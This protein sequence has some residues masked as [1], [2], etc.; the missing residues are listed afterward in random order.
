MPSFLYQERDN[1]KNFKLV[2]RNPSEPE[3]KRP[4]TAQKKKTTE[5]EADKPIPAPRPPTAKNAAASKT[6]VPDGYLKTYFDGIMGAPTY[7]P[8]DSFYMGKDN[9]GR[10]VMK[11]KMENASTFV[12]GKPGE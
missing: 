6:D 1:Y 5:E 2:S 10:S 3:E 7:I 8:K 12:K 9:Q 11:I 4:S